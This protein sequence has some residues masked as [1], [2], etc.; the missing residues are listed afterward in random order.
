MPKASPAG[1]NIK[2]MLYELFGALVREVTQAIRI[3]TLGPPLCE[4][5][6]VPEGSIGL[7]I[8]A[9]ATASGGDVI[10]Y[11]E[12]YVPESGHALVTRSTLRN[13]CDAGPAGTGKRAKKEGDR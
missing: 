13:V 7:G 2:K 6:G 10:Y 8:R 11:Q 1:A 4:V 5:V 9:T 12:L 3:E